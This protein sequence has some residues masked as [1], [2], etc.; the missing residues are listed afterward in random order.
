MGRGHILATL[1]AA[2]GIAHVVR[3]DE[4]DVRLCIGGA[5]LSDGAEKGGEQEVNGFHGAGW[6]FEKAKEDG[7]SLAETSVNFGNETKSLP[8]CGLAHI[9]QSTALMPSLRVHP[10][11]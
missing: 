4:K 8:S 9:H 6:T 5:E 1:H 3:D 10:P 7:L 2:V 11:G